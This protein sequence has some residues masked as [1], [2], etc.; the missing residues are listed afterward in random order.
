MLK[1]ILFAF[2]ISEVGI[3]LGTA[4]SITLLRKTA[5]KNHIYRFSNKTNHN[6]TPE[7]ATLLASMPTSVLLPFA[8]VTDA[9][10]SNCPHKRG[11]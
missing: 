10:T 4:P 7:I 3:Y 6:F 5:F 8:V 2:I 1:N 11:F 9:K